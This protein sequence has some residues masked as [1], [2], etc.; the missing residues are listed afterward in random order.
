MFQSP[1]HTN[2]TKIFELNKRKHLTNNR[3][4]HVFTVSINWS[5]WWHVWSPS[6]NKNV[7]RRTSNAFHHTI[8]S[9]MQG[10]EHRSHTH[11]HALT[12]KT[13][14]S[15]NV[16]RQPKELQLVWQFLLRLVLPILC[17]HRWICWWQ[18]TNMILHTHW[19]VAERELYSIMCIEK[20]SCQRI[21]SIFLCPHIVCTCHEKV[22]LFHQ[23]LVNQQ[24][25]HSAFRNATSVLMCCS[26]NCDFDSDHTLWHS[27][28][29]QSIKMM[30]S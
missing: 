4:L 29:V 2:W 14:K 25:A 20:K 24:S 16:T 10:F 28:V 15:S 7:P 5:E 11:C 23:N 21:W 30:V 26:W 19:N 22:H 8:R 3:R 12:E 1:V 27:L 18:P 6:D 13:N 9:R 17:E